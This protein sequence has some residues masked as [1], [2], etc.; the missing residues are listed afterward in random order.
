MDICEVFSI[1]RVSQMGYLHGLHAGPC[2][3]LLGDDL[4]VP[5]HRNRVFREISETKP[6]LCVVCSPLHLF[7]YH[8]ASV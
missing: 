6:F 1:P 2:Y 8:P 4:L 7:F 5:E 3:D